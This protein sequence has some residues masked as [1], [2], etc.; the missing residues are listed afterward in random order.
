M[1]YLFCLLLFNASNNQTQGPKNPGSSETLGPCTIPSPF[2]N[3]APSSVFLPLHS[4]TSILA[5]L[6][7]WQDSLWLLISAWVK[8]PGNEGGGVVSLHQNTWVGCHP[9]TS[10]KMFHKTQPFFLVPQQEVGTEMQTEQGHIQSK[11]YFF[12]LLTHSWTE[13]AQW[14][15]KENNRMLLCQCFYPHSNNCLEVLWKK[16]LWRYH[17][18]STVKDVNRKNQKAPNLE[19]VETHED[20]ATILQELWGLLAHHKFQVKAPSQTEYPRAI[21]PRG[22]LSPWYYYNE[23]DGNSSVWI[24]RIV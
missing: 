18:H 3:L 12:L 17:F 10:Q 2:P 7:M 14:I 8:F 4:F 13:W 23:A 21:C 15:L 5:K 16:H 6:K 1:N 9:F 20:A 24:P 11:C 19:L 22:P